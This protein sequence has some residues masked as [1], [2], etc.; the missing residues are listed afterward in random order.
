M[1]KLVR[2]DIFECSYCGKRFSSE[3]QATYHE[4]HDHDIVYIGLERSELNRLLG[5]LAVNVDSARELL[6]EEIWNKLFKVSRAR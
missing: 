5:F 4:R 2:Q 3:E 6:T 1:P